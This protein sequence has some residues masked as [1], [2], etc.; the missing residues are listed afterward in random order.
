MRRVL[1]PR[2]VLAMLVL[3]GCSAELPTTP[4]DSAF[5]GQS[6]YQAGL[7]A[8]H[9]DAR[10]AVPIRGT[11]EAAIQPAAPVSPGVIRQLDLGTCR[12]SHL[13]VSEL[14]SDK[15][16]NLA[17]GTQT[18]EVIFTAANGDMLY[19]SGSGTNSMTAPGQVAFRVE[20]TITGGTG[21]FSGA[22]GTVVGE[23]TADLANAQSK[24]AMAGT[25]RY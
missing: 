20:L 1:N 12:L 10:P 25:I 21:R 8:T 13:G 23:G 2:P 22:T 19:A 6:S 3:A 14:V 11:C 4:D 16:I 17:A 15:L 9:Y 7:Q 18:A 5:R 24:L